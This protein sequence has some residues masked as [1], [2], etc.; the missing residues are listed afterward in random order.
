VR[1][2]QDRGCHGHRRK[3]RKLRTDGWQGGEGG[4]VLRWVPPAK[5]GKE[6]GLEIGGVGTLT[7]TSVRC[8]L[9]YASHRLPS[10][11]HHVA[12]LLTLNSD[13]LEMAGGEPTCET[14]EVPQV[15]GL[16]HF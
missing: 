7:H 15:S 13:A 16:V 12:R 6:V 3:G 4:G 2:K 5:L 14:P 11:L 10:N 1:E 9:K 8:S